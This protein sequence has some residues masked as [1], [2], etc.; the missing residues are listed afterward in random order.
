MQ[1]INTAEDF[2]KWAT[3]AKA[4][5]AVVY[6]KGF[7]MRDKMS[8]LPYIVKSGVVPHEFRT[9]NKA[10]DFAEMGLV[11]LF[12]KRTGDGEFDY[13]AVKADVTQ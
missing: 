9:A 13:L 8:R 2:T 12:Q 10:M 11:H 6:Y 3:H 7:L 1:Q 4:G 5:A